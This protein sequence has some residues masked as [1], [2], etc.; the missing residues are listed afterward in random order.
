MA[1]V[2]SCWNMLKL[3]SSPTHAPLKKTS[4]NHH[5]IQ[6]L[7][8]F[9]LQNLPI[10]TIPT[11]IAPSHVDPRPS[12]STPRWASPAAHWRPSRWPPGRG[13]RRGARRGGRGHTWCRAGGLPS[14]QGELG[15][16]WGWGS[17]GSWGDWGDLG[18]GGTW[19]WGTWGWG[20]G[21]E[22]VFHESSDLGRDW[23][24]R[25]GVGGLMFPTRI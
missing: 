16:T 21:G 2:Q 25:D 23:M 1:A 18:T 20:V 19:G 6:K 8:I 15:G 5:Q 11:P 7:H 22:Y 14:P 9:F 4:S 24:G 17:W 3:H 10:P 13:A 12:P